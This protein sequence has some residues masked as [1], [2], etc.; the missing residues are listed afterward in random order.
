L[1]DF[2][3]LSFAGTLSRATGGLKL[4]I[5]SLPGMRSEICRQLQGLMLSQ[6]R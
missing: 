2:A 1:S 6:I 5:A 4:N 3:V